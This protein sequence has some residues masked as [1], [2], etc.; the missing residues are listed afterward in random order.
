VTAVEWTLVGVAV[1]LAV[2]AA[3][4]LALVVAGR[5]S[6]ARALG[7][8]TPVPLLSAAQAK[9]FSGSFSDLVESG[10]MF[11][12]AEAETQ[13]VAFHARCCS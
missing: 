13:D 6:D 11:D 4:V 7:P 2:Y 12:V 9:A 5:R 8:I 3:S 1:P 10:R